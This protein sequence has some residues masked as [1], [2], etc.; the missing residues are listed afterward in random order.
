MK[1]LK[2]IGERTV[3]RLPLLFS[4]LFL[5]IF[6]CNNGDTLNQKISRYKI[7]L[8][9]ERISCLFDNLSKYLATDEER[10]NYFAQRGAAEYLDK[11]K[12][13]DQPYTIIYKEKK[14]YIDLTL[15][16]NKD[17]LRT[18]YLKIAGESEFVDPFVKEIDSNCKTERVEK[19]QTED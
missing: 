2:K 5:I 7:E 9:K 14:F 13:Y 12:R 16:E 17:N 4:I 3:K 8:K 18:F 10:K 11:I 1:K 19:D 6:A 15:L